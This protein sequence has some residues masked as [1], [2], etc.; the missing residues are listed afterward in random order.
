MYTNGVDSVAVVQ[1]NQT[2][3]LA[4]AALRNTS[5]PWVVRAP[6]PHDTSHALYLLLQGGI[7]EPVRVPSN[8]HA[9]GSSVAESDKPVLQCCQWTTDFRMRMRP[10]ELSIATASAK[11]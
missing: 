1:L 8:A 2:Y 10:H 11:R 6:G 4:A 3:H 7:F 9:S 5:A